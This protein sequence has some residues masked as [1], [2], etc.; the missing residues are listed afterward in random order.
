[1]P[2][3]Y[4]RLHSAF[5]WAQYNHRGKT[6]RESTK[7]TE[8]PKAKLHLKHRLQEIGA[9]ALG[10]RKFI[11]PNAE[12]VT[13]SEL[14]DALAAD[15]RL[16]EI[17]SLK[18]SICHIERARHHFG[19]YQAL[20]LTPAVVDAW[21]EAEKAKNALG[22]ATLNRTVGMVRQ[23]FTLA[24]RHGCVANIPHLRQLSELGNARQGFFEADRFERVLAHLPG[25]LQDFARFAYLTGWRKGEIASLTWAD[26][27]L[28]GK[29]VRLRPEHAKNAQGRV[30]VLEGDLWKLIER[31]RANRANQSQFAAT[32]GTG[33]LIIALHVFHHFGEP[34]RDFR[35][36]WARACTMAGCPG[37]LFHDLRRTA[38][39][40]L[41]R[42]SVPER[43]AMEITGHKTR[44]IFDRYNIVSESDL[45]EAQRKLQQ[46]LG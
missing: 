36:A 27:D 24:A 15:F 22:L 21:Y 28:A 45:R 30:L 46:H 33:E 43:I 11:G 7:E 34:I 14:L 41:L 38:A 19:H 37:R 9:D 25:H 42:A 35:K 17:R 20:E 26:V 3:L 39:R 4:K 31:R 23:A 40:N 32:P 44:S 8:E 10:L 29:V 13:V 1:M 18:P 5:F 12:K 2:R 6:Y 16:R